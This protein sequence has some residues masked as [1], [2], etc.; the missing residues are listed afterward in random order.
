MLSRRENEQIVKRLVLGLQILAISTTTL[1]QRVE[2]N[3]TFWHS[4]VAKARCPLT[5]LFSSKKPFVPTVEVFGVCAQDCFV[6]GFTN[7]ALDPS[8]A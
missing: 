5:V 7:Q 8:M 1:D 6:L 4:V 2:N 3:A